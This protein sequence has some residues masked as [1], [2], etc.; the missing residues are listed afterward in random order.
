V[1][2][3]LRRTPQQIALSAVQEDVHCVGVS[4]LSGAHR[5]V[6]P[7]VRTA[8]DAAGGEDIPLVAGGIIPDADV[9]WLTERGVSA[10]YGPGTPLATIVDHVLRLCRDCRTARAL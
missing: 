5:S 9:A 4:I 7:A 6:L 3:G 2:L 1:Y 10:T 8:L